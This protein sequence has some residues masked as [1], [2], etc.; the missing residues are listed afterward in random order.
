M[1]YNKPYSVPIKEWLVRQIA[2]SSEIP[3]NVVSAIVDFQ[4]E[5]AKKALDDCNSVEFSGFGKFM[6]NRKKSLFKMERFMK[7]KDDIERLINSPDTSQQKRVS[8]HFMLQKLMSDIKLLKV[9]I[10]KNENRA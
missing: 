9:K 4:F 6:F 5:G 1:D 8:L 10:E 7:T 3:K 2:E